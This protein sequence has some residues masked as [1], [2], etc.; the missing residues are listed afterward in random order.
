MICEIARMHDGSEANRPLGGRAGHDCGAGRSMAS[1]QKWISFRFGS[2]RRECIEDVS[3][4]LLRTEN[5]V[6]SP[7]EE[8]DWARPQ[9]PSI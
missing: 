7:N 6:A 3:A 4:L 1:E 9:I 2:F 8:G 5:V